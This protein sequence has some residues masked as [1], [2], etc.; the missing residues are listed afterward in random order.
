MTSD[1]EGA[2]W[3]TPRPLNTSGPANST[4]GTGLASG[5]ALS[6]GKHAGRLLVALRHDCGCGDLRTSFV[7]YSDDR[8]ASWQGGAELM[9]LP[10]YGGG[11]TE[12]EVAE[13][14]NGS[15]LLT[16]RNFCKPRPR[17]GP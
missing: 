5:V 7:V 15:V 9:L 6:R 4:W 10:Q 13:L 12:C 1:D 11:F 3:S 2:T 17:L 16:S 14:A 8:G